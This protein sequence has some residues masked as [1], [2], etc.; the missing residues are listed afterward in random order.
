MR[1]H[2]ILLWMFIMRK[3]CDARCAWVVFADSIIDRGDFPFASHSLIKFS[4][5]ERQRYLVFGA[6]G[7]ADGKI[8]F[9][10]GGVCGVFVQSFFKVRYY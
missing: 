4:E 10:D 9:L 3:L 5:S 1:V 6:E 7:A 2:F 8:E